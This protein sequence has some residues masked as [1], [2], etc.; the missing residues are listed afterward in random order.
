MG[1]IVANDG[2]PAYEVSIPDVQLGTSVVIFKGVC[3]RMEKRSNTEWRVLIKHDHGGVSSGNFLQREMLGQ[4]VGDIAV[5]VRYKDGDGLWYVSHCRIELNASVSGGLA[6]HTDGQELVS[7]QQRLGEES[8]VDK[9]SLYSRTMALREELRVFVRNNPKPDIARNPSEEGSEYIKRKWAEM[10]PWV[11]K[12]MHGFELR[13]RERLRLL[14]HEYGERSIYDQ[15]L[16]KVVE[17]PVNTD[18]LAEKI[19]QHLGLLALKADDH[20]ST[21]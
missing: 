1:L 16:G 5:P 7:A 9:D 11:D 21:R 20:E 4:G 6:V 14:L 12:M 17:Q 18:D 10:R 3:P 13:F 19:I 15:F 2:E 8:K